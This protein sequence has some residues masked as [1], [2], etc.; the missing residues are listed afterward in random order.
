[1]RNTALPIMKK[2]C[3]VFYS[4]IL[5]LLPVTYADSYSGA[6]PREA[7]II[8]AP[9]WVFLEPQPGVMDND[10]QGTIQPPRDALIELS[11]VVLEGMTYGWKFTYTPFDQQR[12]VTEEFELT[13]LHSIAAN[14]DRLSLTNIRVRYPSVYCWAEY[15]ITDAIN[16]QRLEWSRARTITSKGVGSADRK[17]E[18]DG[19]RDAYHQAAHNAIR[20][21][22]R[23]S[24]KNKPKCVTGELLIRDNPR[25]YVAGG[26][27]YAE[28]SI[29]LSIKDVIPYEVF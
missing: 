28:I 5:G 27:F 7:R 11:K 25:L 1:M 6:E 26:K 14:D 12:H 9:I 13:S 29:Y 2:I 10:T 22:L 24:L 4:I 18:I 17:L 8:R 3:I 20:T 19:V 23:K 21:Y 15:R 16:K